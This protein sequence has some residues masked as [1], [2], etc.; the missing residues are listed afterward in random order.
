MR[1]ARKPWK[2]TIGPM[3]MMLMFFSYF[4]C[5]AASGASPVEQHVLI[6]NAFTPDYPAN[7][8][9]IQGLKIGLARDSQADF[10]YSYEVLDLARHSND[11]GYFDT[12]SR[13]LK[14][15][16]A[17]HQPDFIIVSDAA[18]G[19]FKGRREPLFPGV[20]IILEGN[21]DGG[22]PGRQSPRS[23]DIPL[24]VDK[25]IEL[26]LQ[27]RPS[28]QTIYV[29]IGNS[30]DERMLLASMRDVRDTYAGRTEFVFMN[31][32]P[33]GK[34]LEL[35][36]TV[37][38]EH[39]AVLFLQWFSDIDGNT[40]VPAKVVKEIV[41]EAGAPVYGVGVHY[42]GSGMVGGYMDNKE[43]TGQDAAQAVLDMLAGELPARDVTIRTAN[44]SYVFDW[45][46]LNRWGIGE[47]RLPDGSR[48]E[49]RETS[50][51]EQ[52]GGYIVGA[53]VLLALQTLLIVGLLINWNRRKRAERELL[54]ANASLQTMA[55]KLI[56][57]DKMKDEFLTRTSHELQTPLHAIINIS[58]MLAAGNYGTVSL[59]QKDELQVILAVSRKLSS[60]VRDIIDIE[61]I[62]RNEMQLELAPVDMKSVAAA[63]ADVFGHL[64]QN[65]RLDISVHIP[66][67]LPPV[68]ADENRI[69]Q[70]LFN[71]I[72]NAV[73]YTARGKVIVASSEDDR[74]VTIRIED[75]GI[76]IP[77]EEQDRIFD[78]FTRG[79]A[80]MSG[81]YGGSGLGLPISRQL[82]ERMNGRIQLEWS[83]PGKGTCISFTLPKADAKPEHADMALEAGREAAEPEDKTGNP[84][85]QRFKILAAD[86]EP[87]NLRVLKSL[88]AGDGYD[89]VAVSSGSEAIEMLKASPDIDLVLMDVMMPEMSGYEACRKIREHY[90][91]HDLPLLMLTVR[92][93]PEDIAAGF[94]AGANDFVIKPFVAKE[95]RARVATL[96][97][98]KQSAQEAL[99]N[100][101][102]F[103]QAQ[104]KPH[105]LYN[106]LSTIISFCYTD[107][108]RAGDLLAH[109]GEYLQRSFTIDNT[110]A[111]VSLENELALTKA[112][113]E[114]EKA[115]FGERLAVEYE[116]DD[117]LLAQ[118]VLPLTIQPLVENSIRHGLMTRKSGGIVKI[119]VKQAQSHMAVS[120]EDNGVGIKEIETVFTSKASLKRPRG[121]G[122]SNIG[123]R[124]MKY[125]GVEL[126]VDSSPDR[127]TAVT[128]SIPDR[129]GS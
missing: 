94:E 63:V 71:L 88:F 87:T 52:Y 128:F 34:M 29:V 124:L 122:L 17:N 25:N 76:G 47:N 103:L 69:W 51:W 98:M 106:A 83:D 82:L 28:T 64:I 11:S 80:G 22:P 73:K 65:K 72:G 120:V 41:A 9:F 113:A 31:E 127:G 40:F 27:T 50:L 49:Y 100:E 60:L 26:I 109:L 91:L 99:N 121:V 116:V 74:S 110:S 129:T 20:P 46:A 119:T 21:A 36:R 4:P 66:D 2:I 112:Y 3:L 59:R 89:V 93:T 23:A 13:Y 43:M 104:I 92:N 42:L 6:V 102:A 58:E 24:A 125:Y 86:D 117:R 57:V 81:Q 16:Y 15:K 118:R 44:N 56:Q 111:T 68:F 62:K 38:G 126:R 48:I 45:R 5:A 12:V 114:I 108:A 67:G 32:L 39:A 33:Y 90:S 14:A 37:S 84:L 101:M 53:L 55:E 54:R 96:M 10:N 19:I 115:R 123:W 77:Q 75:T 95:L 105:F 18:Y 97:M 107:G 79:D 30:A 35:L 61:K 1:S 8:L 78:A 70:V 85:P 7:E